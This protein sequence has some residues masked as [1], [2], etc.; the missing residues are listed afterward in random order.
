MWVVQVDGLTFGISSADCDT[1]HIVLK[2]NLSI[3][4][5]ICNCIRAQDVLPSLYLCPWHQAYQTPMHCCCCTITPGPCK[6]YPHHRHV[7]HAGGRV[8]FQR[9]W[10]VIVAP[11]E[12]R[13]GSG[14]AVSR[15]LG[16]LDFKEP[17]RF[18]ECEPDV[19]RYVPSPEDNLIVMASDGLWDVLSDQEAV[20]CANEALRAA[21]ATGGSSAL[22]ALG[23]GVI[24]PLTD[25]HA[26]AVADALLG[27]AVKRGTADN[28]TVVAMLL[29]Y[30]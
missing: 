8:D 3:Y 24:A 2:D 11:R 23:T 16:D 7:A 10:R 12:G 1:P 9:C 5:A 19:N 27:A 28:V 20:D 25:A 21:R 26:K 29:E 6:A 4:F 15:S 17:S 18:V 30:N 22:A 14:L 13:L